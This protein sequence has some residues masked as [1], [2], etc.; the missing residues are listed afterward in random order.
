ME[1]YD[2]LI[3]CLQSITNHFEIIFV[4][5][6]G[7]DN[8]WKRIANLAVLDNRVKG[9][10]LSRNFGQH[11]AITAGMENSHGEWVVVMDCDLQDRPQVIEQLYAKAR[12]GYDQVIATRSI[13]HDKFLKKIFSKLFYFA[14][15]FLT[16][17]KINK[18]IGNFGIYSRTVINAIL[19][20]KEQNKSFG[21]QAVW[22]GF[23]RFELEVNRDKR[24]YGKSTYSFSK[25][26]ILAI[27]SI[28]SHSNRLLQLSIYLG[29]VMSMSSFLVAGWIS[30]RYV[31]WD[32]ELQGWSSI[33]VSIFFATGLI[34]GMI[35]I[36]GLYIGRIFD[37]AKSR[38]IYLIS[39]KT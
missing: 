22:V 27:D 9:I 34:L 5:D 33:V 3:I 12:E 6:C 35:G 38:P 17:E 15:Q 16:G 1:L 31:I 8:S 36:L 37:E 28:L 39:E 30:L 29:A 21:L 18:N 20:M 23:S 26:L 32:I 24:P 25:S 4:E 2:Q 11:S 19:E 10:K 14:F 7:I 13:R